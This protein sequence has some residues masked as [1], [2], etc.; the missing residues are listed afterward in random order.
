LTRKYEINLE[1]D[2]WLR[3]VSIPTKLYSA[4]QTSTPDRDMLDGSG[5][6]H[7]KFQRINENIRKEVPFDKIVK[8]YRHKDD[9]Y[10]IVEENNFDAQPL[11]KQKP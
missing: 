10:V 7:I 2:K 11:K 4:V 3:L 8:G 6:V 5:H 9:N 1:R